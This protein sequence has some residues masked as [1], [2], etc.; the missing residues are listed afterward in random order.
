MSIPVR[1]KDRGFYADNLREKDAEFLVKTEKELG[2]WMERLDGKPHPKDPKPAED[3]KEPE[4]KVD[5]TK[6][7]PKK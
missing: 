4:K 7:D 5:E 1:A 6:P 2:K 3:K